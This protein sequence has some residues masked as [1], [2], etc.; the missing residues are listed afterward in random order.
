MN[1]TTWL[2]AFFAALCVAVL[3]EHVLAKHGFAEP[4]RIVVRETDKGIEIE[5]PRLKALI[6]RRGYVSGVAG[7]TLVDKQTGARDLGFGL[8]I[9]DWIMEPGSDAGYRDQ[10]PDHM[11]YRFNNDYHGRQ[12][13][14]CLE[15]PQ[16]CTKAG[17][18]NPVVTR[19][20]DFVAVQWSYRYPLAAPGKN[21]GS[22][23]TQTL[24][25]PDDTRYFLSCDRID[26]VN[27]SPAMFFRL[28]M[29]GHIKHSGGDSFDHIY[30]SY[31]GKLPADR[32][33]KNFPPD[34][35]FRYRR[36][37]WRKAHDTLPTRFI[38]AY[39]IADRE[40]QPMPYLAGMTLDPADVYA[41]WCHQRGYV[42]MI[43]EIG[44]RPIQAGESFSA[45]FVVGYFDSIDEMHEV[46]DRYRGHSA[47]E[48]SADSWRLK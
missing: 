31:L 47:L 32:F 25:F 30:L 17:R 23:W 10:L 12:P 11:V 5:T 27:D 24:V 33:M 4:G 45:A 3:V 28:D 41:A 36:D 43:Q 7:G 34:A 6:R 29:P 15:G 26:A 22:I 9:A 48:V 8:D 44:G 21:S 38:R 13:K 40:G 1:R 18:L 35:R 19:G 46:Y 39:K 14:R 37:A 42:C 20:P 2:R 16:I